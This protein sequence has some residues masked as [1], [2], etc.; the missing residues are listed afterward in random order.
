MQ[1]SVRGR[2]FPFASRERSSSATSHRQQRFLVPQS[3]AGTSHR[4]PNISVNDNEDRDAGSA[5]GSLY[6]ERAAECLPAGTLVAGA[7][8]IGALYFGRDVFVPLALAVLLSFV[9]A[10]LAGRLQRFRLGRVASVLLVVVVAFAALFS[11]FG[12]VGTQVAQLAADL[13]AYQI[14][15]QEKI[16][17]L[18]GAGAGDGAFERAGNVL[19]TLDK[20]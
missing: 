8:V 13:P 14:T 4:D 19:Q 12:Y 5:P 10:P 9:L 11:L 2:P 18:R 3:K 15:I 16:R 6:P 1:R 20:N 17:T 7:I